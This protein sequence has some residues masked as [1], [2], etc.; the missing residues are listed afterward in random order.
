MLYLSEQ[1]S[2]FKTIQKKLWLVFKYL[3][4]ISRSQQLKK[5]RFFQDFSLIEETD[6]AT[7]KKYC[8]LN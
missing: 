5:F 8:Y 7:D 3:R 6:S 1:H 2:Q 4:F